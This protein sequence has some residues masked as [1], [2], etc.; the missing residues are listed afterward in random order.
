MAAFRKRKLSD[1]DARIAP[2]ERKASDVESPPVVEIEFLTPAP[3]SGESRCSTANPPDTAEPPD[4]ADPAG[5]GV[6]HTQDAEDAAT[7]AAAL[8]TGSDGVQQAVLHRSSARNAEPEIEGGSAV[9]TSFPPP[10]VVVGPIA[11]PQLVIGT[12]SPD[13]EP[14][15][16]SDK[17]RSVPFRPDTVIDGWSSANITVRG[18][19]LRGHLHR[20]NGA[21][22]QDDF[23]VHLLQDGRV[24]GVVADGVSQATQ[25]HLGASTAVRYAVQWLQ[26]QLP[27][28][29][30]DTDW[31]ALVKS[32]AWGLTEQARTLLGLADPDPVAAE[33]ALATTLICGVVEPCGPDELRA[34]VLGVGDSGVWILRND[35]F[36]P[37]LGGKTVGD[38]GISSSAVAGLPR[39]PQQITASVVSLGAEDVLLLGTDGIGDP[40]GGGEGG[41]GNLFRELF[42]RPNPP[43]QFEFAHALDF[44]RETFDDDRTLVAVM[45]RDAHSRRR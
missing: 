18:A 19:S 29:T 11:V 28:R 12:A 4:S 42:A 41:V 8:D 10:A 30:E 21:P 14:T 44:S 39:V 38:G 2:S 40:L 15:P 17:F 32:V 5:V 43:S 35:E 36:V 23:A 24:V 16:I 20:Y 34:H 26:S 45:L 25:S 27:A 1:R 13:V 33:K 9:A 22:R 6:D 31:L 37:I 3:E 7:A